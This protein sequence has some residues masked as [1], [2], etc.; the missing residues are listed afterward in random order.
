M[1]EV[2]GDPVRQKH[3]VLFKEGVDFE[4]TYFI[5]TPGITKDNVACAKSKWV[6]SP[7]KTATYISLL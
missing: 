2:H 6:Q 4:P 1:T 3:M 7:I 5:C